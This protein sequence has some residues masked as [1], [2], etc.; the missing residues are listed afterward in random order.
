MDNTHQIEILCKILKKERI[1]EGSE[2][3]IGTVFDVF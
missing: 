2:L 3:D 1:K